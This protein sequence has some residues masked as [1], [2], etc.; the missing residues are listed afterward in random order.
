MTLDRP[1][2]TRLLPGLVVAAAG[3]LAALGLHTFADAL[4]V[5]TAAVLLG[6]V[7]RALRPLPRWAEA[8]TSFARRRL[9][10]VGIVLLGLELSVDEVLELGIPTL[11]LVVVTV[12]ATFLLTRWLGRLA[13][14]PAPMALFI[15]TGFSICGVSAVV[16]MSGTR[17]HDDE[18]VATAIALVTVCGSLAILVMPLLRGPLG[19]SQHEFGLWVGASVH[20]VGQVVATAGGVSAVALSTAVLVKLVRVLLLAPMVT[21]SSLAARRAAR[22]NES[23]DTPPVPLVPGFVLAFLVMVTLRSVGA[24]PSSAL[25]MA[26]TARSLVLA[27]A[28]FSLGA[29]LD[30]RSLAVTGRRAAA[31][32]LASWV[33]VAGISYGGLHLLP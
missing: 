17:R 15:A 9:L 1:A 6:V 11:V 20:D 5:L 12:L 2:R 31:V 33:I 25:D 13:G 4:N 8:G 7:V 24:V 28:L 30:L 14:L 18:D 3:A 32:G 19:L 10:Q 23:G 21:A 29:S 16:A 27:A 26:T 22:G